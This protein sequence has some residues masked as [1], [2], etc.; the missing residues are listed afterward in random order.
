MQTFTHRFIIRKTKSKRAHHASIYARIN[1]NGARTEISVNR[2]CDPGKWDYKS[3]RI[4][5]RTEEAREMN[6]YLNSIELR[7]FTTHRELVT[8]KVTINGESFRNVFSGQAEKPRMIVEI[9]SNHNARFEALVGK[10]YSINTFK[11]YR[12][13]L[14]SL[15]DFLKWKYKKSDIDIREIGFEFINDFEFFL[16]TERNLQHNSTMGDIKRV[17]KI[18]HECV[19]KNWLDKDPFLG[20]KVRIKDTSREILLPEE[21]K[22]M[23]DKE[24]NVERLS[25][26]RDIFLFSCYTGLSFSDVAKLSQNHLGTG[27]DGEQWIFISR[28]KTDVGSRIPLLPVAVSLIYKYQAHPKTINSGKL[29]PM[30]SNQKMNSYLKEVADICEINKE[31]TFHCAR[32][33]FATTVTLSNGVPIETVGKMLGHKNLRTTQIYAKILDRKVSDDMMILKKKYS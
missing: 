28:T 20:Y 9:F 2:F 12:T 13:C 10:E 21:L 1:I 22:T 15:K 19:A 26:V 33:T 18:V 23:E 3:G 31:L 32:H 6:E 27:I 29:F 24:I 11:K 25:L 14:Q 30:L 4:I 7:I 16:K 17:K 8:S 5:G